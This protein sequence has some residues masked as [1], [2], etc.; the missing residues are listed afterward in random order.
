[1][2][3]PL[4]SLDEVSIHARRVARLQDLSVHI[5]RGITA[6]LGPSGAGKTSLCNLLVGFEKPHAGRI[7]W[8]PPRL[9]SG[10]LPLYWSSADGL[11][12]HLD[13]IGHL[14]A[15]AP[16]AARR[17]LPDLLARFAL[18][19]RA[20]ARPHELSA[21]ERERLGVARALASEALVLVL[22][23][24]FAH[25]DASAATRCW[26]ALMED[27]RAHGT[28]LIYSTHSPDRVVGLAGEMICLH[29][30]RL[31]EHGTVDD[32]YHRPP[33][34]QAAAC[35]GEANWFTAEDKPWFPA[36]A[37]I[38][39]VRPER[40]LISPDG[41]GDALVR[42]SSFHG[43]YAHTA[44]ILPAHG[45][46]RTFIHRPVEPLAP[47][48]R[49]RVAVTPAPAPASGPAPER[50]PLPAAGLFALCALAL[51]LGAAGCGDQAT[52]SFHEEKSW[53]LPPVAATLPAPRGLGRLGDDQVLVL[54]TAGRVMVYDGAGALVRQWSMPAYDIG[55]P[56]GV[57]QLPDGRIAVA[58]THYHRVVLFDALTGRCPAS[59]EP[60]AMGRRSSSSRSGWP[61]IPPATSTSP[62]TAATTGCRNS[63]PRSRRWRASAASASRPENSSARRG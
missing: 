7:T 46:S 45:C 44:A 29:E 31:L 52:L 8:R 62:N 56:E 4:W 54:D 24:P 18:E 35:L 38:G 10:R 60:R 50:S 20:Q 57:V 48:E 59:S 33:T 9:G 21:G 30:G 58:D 14:A 26:S 53:N 3:E 39:C 6:I 11:W 19:R 49:V 36:A 28:A 51:A 40:L 63:P 12:P 13:A 15:V 43:A 41:A 34:R 61:P 23:E 27:V 5:G 22:D 1:M 47:G 2:S 37:V 17:P 55:R 42:T 16:A 32:L 25:V